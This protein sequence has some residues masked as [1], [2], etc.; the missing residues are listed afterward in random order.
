M[1]CLVEFA[2]SCAGDDETSPLRIWHFQE[3]ITN[4]VELYGVRLDSSSNEYM[5]RIKFVQGMQIL[6]IENN[7]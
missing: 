3:K 5:F 1:F 4:S 2:A 7:V 6:R